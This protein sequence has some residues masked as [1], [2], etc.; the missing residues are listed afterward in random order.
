VAPLAGDHER[1]PLTQQE[2]FMT[3]THRRLASIAAAAC[4][5]VSAGGA[6]ASA[7][8]A[9]TLTADK[10]CYVNAGPGQDAAMTITGTQWEPANTV[11]LSGGTAFAN[12]T[13]D[14]SGNVSFTTAAPE[15]SGTDPGTKATTLT[16]TQDNPDG[17]ILTATVAVTSANLSVETFPRSVRN[18]RKDKVTF[19]FSGFV[20]NKR[21]YG[22]YLVKKKIVAKDKFNKAHGACGV[23]KQKA[24]LYP[25]G[26]PKKDKYTVT[27]EST[28]HYV[29]NAF[30]RITGTLNILHF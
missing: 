22:Y 15:L 10:A 20:P 24:L 27:F 7:A 12:A 25:G 19:S 29:K 28:S 2:I 8:S 9:A 1:V 13:P 18:V 11:Q 17:T 23:L 4:C 3:A 26:R 6:I 16:A 21:I 14:A 30:P 5:A